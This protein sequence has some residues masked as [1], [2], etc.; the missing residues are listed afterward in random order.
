LLY[1]ETYDIVNK[2]LSPYAP[3]WIVGNPVLKW[4][5]FDWT[6]RFNKVKASIFSDKTRWKKYRKKPK[7]DVGTLID[8]IVSRIVLCIHEQLTELDI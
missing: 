5:L 2:D 8:K 4:T 7:S 6:S 3:E 1:R